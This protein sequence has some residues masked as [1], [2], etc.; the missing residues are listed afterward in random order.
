MA[1]YNPYMMSGNYASP[2]WAPAQP[3]PVATPPMQQSYAA[4]QAPKAMEWVQGEV[5]AQA[6]QMPPGWPANQP[7]PLWDSTDMI[8][9]MKSWNPMGVPNPMQKLT[10]EMPETQNQA[11]LSGSTGT[12][13]DNKEMKS[14]LDAMREEIRGL[15]EAIMQRGNSNATASVNSNSNRNQ[16]GSENVQ[17]RGGNR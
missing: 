15:K 16:N 8:I 4:P 9:W 14:E 17:N 7:I 6:F 1:Y 12:S 5:G 11:L 13:N 10:Y 2:N 3:I